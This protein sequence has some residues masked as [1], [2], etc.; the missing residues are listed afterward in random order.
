[1]SHIS[2]RA[3]VI[4]ATIIILATEAIGSEVDANNA[5]TDTKIIRHL[6]LV[7]EQLLTYLIL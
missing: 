6:D 1:M 4:D 3:Y 2:T 5:P 7:L